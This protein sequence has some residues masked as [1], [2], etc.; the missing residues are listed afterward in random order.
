MKHE[1]Y[2]CIDIV[3]SEWNSVSMYLVALHYNHSVR[4]VCTC[5]V[6]L[7]PRSLRSLCIGAGMT[8]K[9]NSETVKP[10]PVITRGLNLGVLNGTHRP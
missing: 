7:F 3:P 1:C 5:L 6:I 4:L 8:C 10:D 9:L 2:T